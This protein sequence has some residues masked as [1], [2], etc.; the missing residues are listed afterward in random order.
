MYTPEKLET[1][2]DLRLKFYYYS[3]S[4]LD[5]VQAC[6]EVIRAGRIEN[7]RKEYWCA[8]KFVDLSHDILEKLREFLKSL[9]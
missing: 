7:S 6:G 3:A 9:Y 5:W 4:G 2:Q 8:V 1:G